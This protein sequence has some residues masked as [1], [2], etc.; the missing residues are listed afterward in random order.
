M[1]EIPPLP[2]SGS[3]KNCGLAVWSLVLGILAVVLSVVC[4]GPLFAIP[5]VICGHVAY[6]RINRSAGDM[7]GQGLA[8]GGLITGYV[9]IAMIPLIAMLAAIAIPNFVKARDTAQRNACINNLRQIDGAKLAWALEQKKKDGD[10]ATMTDISGFLRAGPLICP[11]GGVYQV[12]PVGE[13]PTCSIPGHELSSGDS[14]VP[15]PSRGTHL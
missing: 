13:A 10:P 4:I 11:K 2:T 7:S 12:N 3:P 8:L 15:K 5:A 6:S 1:N 14:P 9:S